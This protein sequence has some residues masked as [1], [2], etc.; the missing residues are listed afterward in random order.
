[1]KRLLW[2]KAKLEIRKW[3]D[4]VRGR[5]SAGGLNTLSLPDLEFIAEHLAQARVFREYGILDKAREHSEKAL[6]RFPASID[7]AERSRI[8][9]ELAAV[10]RKN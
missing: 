2:P 6:A 7:P 5:P 10:D 3:W 1:M 9:A 8:L 4:W